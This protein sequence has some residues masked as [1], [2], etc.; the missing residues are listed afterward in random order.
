MRHVKTHKIPNTALLFVFL[1]PFVIVFYAIYEFNPVHA[2][3]IWLYVLQ[4]FADLI[5]F[6][7]LGALWLTIILDITQPEH[8]R[9]EIQYDPQF[10]KSRYF[11]ID[12]L[13]PVA[14]EPIDLL[15]KTLIAAV[16]IDYPHKTYI[17]DDGNSQEVRMLA[18]QL[19]IY[20]I[21]RPKIGKKHAKS[22]NINYAL[23]YITGEFFI[24]FDA[25]H[26]PKSEFITELLPFFQNE[27]V[28][29]VQTPQ[30]YVNTHNFIA[31]GTAQAQEVFYK[32]VQPAKNSFNAS[33]CVGTNVMYRRK[34]IDEI[35]GLAKRDHSE[36]IWTTILLHEKKWETIFYNRI[37]AVGRAPESIPSFF[38]QQNRWAR[39][40]FTLFFQKNPFFVEGLTIDQRLQYFFSNIHYFS[41]FAIIIYLTMPLFY[42][43]TGQFPMNLHDGGSW[44]I[45]YLPYAIIIYLLPLYL[46]GSMRLATISTAMVS[47]APYLQAFFS[48]ILK[49]QYKWIATESGKKRTTV[50]IT[51]IW[52]HLLF[53]LLALGAILVGWYNPTDVTTTLVTTFWTLFNMYIIFV[54]IK[55]GT[56]EQIK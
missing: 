19:G 42:L 15:R 25:D 2:G 45:H 16:A 35:G 23:Q 11:S 18:A 37:L 7:T 8:N 55:N 4:I 29:L 10:L 50:L 14:N 38:R 28:G 39:G 24:V 26:I 52:P 27:N 41:G 21:A 9:R 5:A 22:G 13:V 12:V 54:F 56:A 34:A 33:F 36:D 53:M 47:F 6:C 30:F 43:Y 32:Y 20:Y 46:L 3:N 49:N 1:A 51:Y 48:T 17:L 40:G 44:I 31:S